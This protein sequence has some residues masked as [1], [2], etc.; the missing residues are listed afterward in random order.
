MHAPA[1]Y[2]VIGN[3]PTGTKPWTGKI[4]GLAIYNHALTREKVIKHFE[5]WRGGSA[6]SLLKEQNIIA[7]YPLDEKS[8]QLIHNAVSNRLHLSIPAKFKILKKNFLDLSDNAFKLNGS[9]LRDLW[10]NILGFVPL[11]FLLFL[12][13]KSYSQPLK[14]SAL[15]ITILTVVGGTALSLFVEILQAYLPAR[16]SSLSDLIFN[17]AGTGLGVILALAFIKLKILFI[18]RGSLNRNC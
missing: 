12:V 18:G 5:K 1:R 11:G 6:L 8:G 15:R 13:F 14:T 3:D 10:I 4:H 17:S 16:N 7:L 9:N 2:M